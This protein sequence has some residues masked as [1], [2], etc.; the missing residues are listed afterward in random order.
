MRGQRQIR[1]PCEKGF[2]S[3]TPGTTFFQAARRFRKVTPR[4][5]GRPDRSWPGM[6][7]L[8]PCSPQTNQ[9]SAD[10]FTGDGPSRRRLSASAPIPARG[11]VRR[12]ESFRRP[13]AIAAKTTGSRPARAD[14]FS[15]RNPSAPKISRA[16]SR[17][18]DS[19]KPCGRH[20]SIS[21]SAGHPRLDRCRAARLASGAQKVAAR[22]SRTAQLRRN[23]GLIAPARRPTFGS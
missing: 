10:S 9:A 12:A 3:T 2:T 16:E 18:D 22:L 4:N 7:G 20:R 1:T 14:Y 8:P 15:G 11:C 5:F 19:G 13:A 23:T 21:A 6:S 17:R